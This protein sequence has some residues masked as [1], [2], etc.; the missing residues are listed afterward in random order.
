MNPILLINPPITGKKPSLLIPSLGLGYLASALRRQGL[1][2][3]IIDA[4][5]MAMDFEAVAKEAAGIQPQM[6][7]ITCTTPLSDSAYKLARMLRSQAKFLILG[8]AHASALGAKVFQECPEFDFAFLGE[9]EE[10]FPAFAQ[11]LLSGEKNPE[12]PGVIWPGHSS[13]PVKISTPDRLAFPAWD[14]MPMKNYRHPLFPG[15]QVATMISSRGCP[16]QCVFCD[17]SVCGSRFRPRSPENVLKEIE[18]LRHNLGVNSIIF[19]DD[20]FTLDSGRVIEICKQIIDRKLKVKWKCEGRVNLVDEQALEWMKK[21]GCR[22]I[23]YGMES[24]N[25]KS[26]DWLNK[27]VKVEQIKQAV[28]KTREAGIKVLGYFIFGVPVETFE[29]ELE[30]VEFAIRLDLDYVQFASLSP[31]PGSKLYDIAVAKGWYRDAKGPGPEE[32]GERRPLLITD[33]WT[34]DRL[35]LILREAYRKFYLRPG[36]ILREALNPRGFLDLVKSGFRLTRWLEKE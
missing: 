10:S 19:Y 7:G 3:K 16:Y 22:M 36:Y 33:Y 31:F 9:A 8:G 15:D 6:I 13:E 25:Q 17:K 29:D 28:R 12:F 26:L 32:Y 14:L 21:A 5:A 27:G 34:E 23:A 2:A 18:E 35:K 1:E 11:K 4:P 24:G 30:S 20:L